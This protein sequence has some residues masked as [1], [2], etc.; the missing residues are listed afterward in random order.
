MDAASYID[1]CAAAHL[2][3]IP[4]ILLALELPGP[5]LSCKGIPG[6][7]RVGDADCPLLADI[8]ATAHTAVL[9][10]PANEISDPGA[11][12]LVADGRCASLVVLNLALNGIGAPGC[13]ALAAG[14][15]AS[16]PLLEELTLDGNPLG[17]AGGVAL[18]GLVEAHPRLAHLRAARCDFGPDALIAL[19]SALCST[20]SLRLLD[21]S[22]PLLFSRNE[23]TSGHFARALRANASLVRLVLRKHPHAGDATAEWLCDAL[24][25]NACLRELD[26][27][28]NAMG[29][30]AGVA[31]AAAL[32]AGAG[33]TSLEL[34][35]CRLGDRG[36]E[37]LAGAIAGPEC[38]LRHLDLRSNGIGVKGV[39][40]IMAAL[41]APGCGLESCFLWGNPGLKP[42][43]GAEAVLEALRSG[44]VRAVTDL[45]PSEVDGEAQVAKCEV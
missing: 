42:G 18:A 5:E 20:T 13:A 26:L 44:E 12:A 45:R 15:R 37:A 29:P 19:A 41:C 22:E 24:L 14:L 39:V 16:A 43:E 21:L 4:A 27:S 7:R 8:V 35:S 33:L 40:A 28:A 31:F 32:S 23:E 34:G 1:A 11:T 6:T 9:S 36:A 30:P 3:P 10:L 25:D 17:E 38:T 2:S